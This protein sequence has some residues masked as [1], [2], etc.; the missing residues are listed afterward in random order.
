MTD[1]SQ[2]GEQGVILEQLPVNRGRF[3]D[4]GAND[5]RTFSNTRALAELGWSGLHF[6]PD[7]RAAA[8]LRKL[9]EG[10]KRHTI[11]E[12]AVTAYSCEIDMHIFDDALVST[13]VEAERDKWEKKAGESRTIK[14]KSI[15]VDDLEYH[16]PWPDRKV[17]VVSIDAEGWSTHIAM[18]L[19]FV[20]WRVAVIVM[21]RGDVEETWQVIHR[22]VHHLGYWLV[23]IT[24]ENLIFRMG[25]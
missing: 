25:G 3:I 8:V 20:E 19:P 6:E 12:A 7:P 23:A 18:R 9:Y 10:D 15:A 5:G 2:R 1:Y 4:I 16:F 22:M 21:E 24:A 14:V 13:T 11:V 17:D